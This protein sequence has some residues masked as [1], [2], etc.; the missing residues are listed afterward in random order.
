MEETTISCIGNIAKPDHALMVLELLKAFYRAEEMINSPGNAG[1]RKSAAKKYAESFQV[2]IEKG[3][4]LNKRLSKDAFMQGAP[5]WLA[6]GILLEMSLSPTSSLANRYRQLQSIFRILGQVE[7]DMGLTNDRAVTGWACFYGAWATADWLSERDPY[8]RTAGTPVMYDAIERSSMAKKVTLALSITEKLHS[9]G[10]DVDQRSTLS[11]SSA[12]IRAAAF[13][14]LEQAEWLIRQGADVNA[15]DI[16]GATPIV[17]ALSRDFGIGDFSTRKRAG[18]M[19]QML[20]DHGADFS[21]IAVTGENFNN[22]VVQCKSL[23]KPYKEK[24]KAIWKAAIANDPNLKS[25]KIPAGNFTLGEKITPEDIKNWHSE[26]DFL[27]FPNI[28]LLYTL[29]G[30]LVRKDISQFTLTDISTLLDPKWNRINLGNI[31]RDLSSKKLEHL[32]GRIVI[33][34]RLSVFMTDERYMNVVR[35]HETG[36]Y[37]IVSEE[38]TGVIANQLQEGFSG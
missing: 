6:S 14:N 9:L 38:S 2:F 5:V 31:S 34:R 15:R 3:G 11:G 8:L 27:L 16:N 33:G 32:L 12:L 26:T 35:D 19:V 29:L 7:L 28:D 13:S 21:G 10:V 22:L 18:E 24:F 23:K 4:N 30:Y 37:A 25:K 17:H 36:I 1:M 20:L